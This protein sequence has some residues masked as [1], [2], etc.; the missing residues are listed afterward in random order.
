MKCFASVLLLCLF[1]LSHASVFASRDEFFDPEGAV[2]VIRSEAD[3]LRLLQDPLHDGNPNSVWFVDFYAPWCGFCRDMKSSWEAFAAEIAALQP[4]L[5]RD[6]SLL[7]EFQGRL[8]EH[9]VRASVASVDCTEVPALQ[10]RYQ[11]YSYPT[12]ILFTGDGRQIKYD[13]RPRSVLGFRTFLQHF[14]F[15]PPE[16]SEVELQEHR[17]QEDRVVAQQRIRRM[18]RKF[19]DP[20]SRTLESKTPVLGS[21]GKLSSIQRTLQEDG[22]ML[23]PPLPRNHGRS[24]DFVLRSPL[25]RRGPAEVIR[26]LLEEIGVAYQD[27]RIP[28]VSP[29]FTIPAMLS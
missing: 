23:F 18:V 15:Y 4:W 27:I 6:G 10:R 8:P 14:G 24:V 29:E 28:R 2:R 1:L 25:D 26:L 13:Q 17:S 5:G 12:L 16:P 3:F 7:P 9:P 22:R 21:P 20:R 19:N 11:V